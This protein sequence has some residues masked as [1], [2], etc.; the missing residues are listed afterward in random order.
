MRSCSQSASAL[1]THACLVRRANP[2]ALPQVREQQLVAEGAA[3]Q[4]RIDELSAQQLEVGGQLKQACEE[5]EELQRA[6]EEKAQYISTL[7]G[8]QLPERS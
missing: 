3:L 2:A 4:Q 5:R 1:V 6:V 7:E 8:T